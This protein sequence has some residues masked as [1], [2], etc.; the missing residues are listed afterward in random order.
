MSRIPRIVIVGRPNVGKSS[1]LNWIAGKRLAI[2][3]DFEGV[4]RDRV[5]FVL[6]IRDR[7]VEVYDTG[8]VGIVD[9]DQLSDHV[10]EQIRLAMEQAD[11][12]LFALDARVG[13]LPLDEE[14]ARRLHSLNKPTILVATKVDDRKF[15][16]QAEEFRRLM[17]A[18]VVATSAHQNRGK[19]D[20]FGEI[21]RLL[22][23]RDAI[24]DATAASLAEPEMKLA[25]VGRRNVGK[26]TFVNTLLDEKRMIVS[27]VPG[28]TR[29]SVDVRFLFDGK[30]IL[31]IDTPGVK[32]KKSV[33]NDLEFYSAHRA[34]RS[35]RRCD[36]ALMFF[37]AEQTISK[38]D[39]QFCSYIEENY[40]PCILVVNKWDLL[41]GKVATQEWADYLRETFPS[42]AYMPI[43]F[44]TGM[45]GKNVKTLL[46]HARMLFKQS[47]SRVTTGELNRALKAALERN[48]PPLYGVKTPKVFYATQ[49][50]EAPPTIVL[51]CNDDEG[52]APSYRRYLLNQLRDVLPY[53]EVP[54][55]LFFEKRTSRSKS[56]VAEA[57]EAE[58]A[59]AEAEADAEVDDAP[60]ML[61][62]EEELESFDELE[63]EAF[64]DDPEG[65]RG[66]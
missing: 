38:V 63:G 55:R 35:V 44:I 12:L 6:P 40:K 34:E 14:V 60:A 51:M 15:D 31:A 46:A 49:I 45:T 16:S 10:E 37:D 1:L 57:A 48:P 54:I 33:S 4:T 5:S 7:Y 56:S 23:P 66:T 17:T 58:M 9:S 42:L 65:E 8:G 36:V 41:Y 29:D 25:I 43:A 26:S 20:L 22:P 39:K 24:E 47:R 59:K 30:P 3:D 28:T 32:K 2:V 52:F 64:A 21:E 11:V 13:M 62:A 27:E 18:P 19:D 53:G 61:D 50:S